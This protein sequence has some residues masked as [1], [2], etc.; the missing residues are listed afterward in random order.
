MLKKRLQTNVLFLQYCSTINKNIYFSHCY[1]CLLFKLF[2]HF[3]CEISI[4][5]TNSPKFAAKRNM[6]SE[7]ILEILKYALNTRI[8]YK[9]DFCRIPLERNVRLCLNTGSYFLGYAA[10]VFWFTNSVLREL[11]SLAGERLSY[12]YRCLAL[13]STKVFKKKGK[14]KERFLVVFNI[15]EPECVVLINT[16]KF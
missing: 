6:N 15:Y 2:I 12:R 14:I 4:S 8:P 10:F 9:W 16:F 5:I 7:V 11:K 13:V 1:T 3:T